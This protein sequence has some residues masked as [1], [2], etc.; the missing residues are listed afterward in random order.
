[1]CAGENVAEVLKEVVEV[2]EITEK[3]SAATTDN[4]R[5]IVRAIEISGWHRIP[6]FGHTLQLAIQA[7]FSLPAIAEILTRCRR[8]VAHFKH[9]V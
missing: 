5:N 7:R 9:H 8:I 3:I 4:G 6:C 2:W 1:M